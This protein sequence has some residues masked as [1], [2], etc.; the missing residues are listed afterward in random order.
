[1]PYL[2]DT[3][4]I[5]ELRKAS[6]CDPNLLKWAQSTASEQH[7]L[8]LLTFGE[9][10]KGIEMLRRRSPR[11]C[12]AFESWLRQL[13]QQ[14]R[15][16]VLPVSESVIDRWGHLMATRTFPV[17]DGFLAATALTFDLTLVTRNVDDFAGAGVDLVNPF[18]IS[19]GQEAGNRG[20]GGEL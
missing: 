19:G 8:S 5:S 14:Y 15:D 1:M 20:Q 9:I 6:A 10:R 7:F 13:Q 3:N 12:D 16:N 11:Q 18:G 17:I 2:L 4:V